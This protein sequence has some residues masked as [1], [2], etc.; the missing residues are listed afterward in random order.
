[1]AVGANSR[2][3]FQNS[4]A[5]GAGSVTTRDN[6]IVLGRAA[7]T[8]NGANT[9]GTSVTIADIAASTAAQSGP[10][11]IM[12]VDATGTIGRDT[13]LRP[14]IVSLQATSV[15]Q[16]SAIA[17]LQAGLTTVNGQIASLQ[18]G[19]EELFDLANINRKEARR[20]I[21]AASALVAAP[22][23]SEP[24]KTSVVGGTA[25]YRGEGAFSM[26]FNHRLNLDIPMAIGGGVAHSGGKDTV[27]RAH[28][29]TEF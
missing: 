26:S 23:P 29:A 13:T 1:L 2:S 9:P 20:G 17:A 25:F 11:D 5:I 18:K 14:A 22:M 7:S 10:T 19:Q 6:Q 28:F 12:T 8:V 3:N 16:G 15:T 4:S 21:A 24:G 27:V